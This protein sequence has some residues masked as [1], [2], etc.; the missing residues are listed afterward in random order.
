MKE[1]IKKITETKRALEKI[2]RA[3]IWVCKWMTK[4]TM[5]ESGKPN[6]TNISVRKQT[7]LKDPNNKI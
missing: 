1:I 6:I 2:H 7:S 5:E 4:L 3:I